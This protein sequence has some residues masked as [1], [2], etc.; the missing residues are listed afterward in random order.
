M[1][2]PK[3]PLADAVEIWNAG[4]AAVDAER[5]VFEAIGV[6]NHVLS[7]ASEAF[8]IQRLK[9]IVVVGFGKC[10][11]AMAVGLER[12]L[13]NLPPQIELIGLVN[14]PEGQPVTTKQIEVVPC[15]AQASN[16]PTETVVVQTQR[17]LGCSSWLVIQMLKRW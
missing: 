1:K 9:K 14:A 7:I 16:F 11:A 5:V 13:E 3:S 8:E 4:V 2:N 12:A 17:M 15:R 10:S 6:R